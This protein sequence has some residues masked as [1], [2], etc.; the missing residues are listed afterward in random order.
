MR[1]HKNVFYLA[2]LAFLLTAS[3]SINSQ[4]KAATTDLFISEYIEGSSFNKAIEIYNGTGSDVDLSAYSLE[5]YSNGAATASQTVALSGTLADGDVFVLAHA[6]A[7]PAILAVADLLNSSVINFNGD[8]AVVLRKDGAVVDA[9]GQ[10][11]FDL[12]QFY[13]YSFNNFSGI[14]TFSLENTH[15]H[16]RISIGYR[17]S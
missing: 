6:S 17:T 5:L 11:G 1:Q 4:V 9:F 14:G 10:I 12:F 3:L 8:D 16:R 2:L 13:F 15:V 7:D